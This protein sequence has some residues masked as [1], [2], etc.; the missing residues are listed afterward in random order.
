MNINVKHGGCLQTYFWIEDEEHRQNK[1][2][3]T[4][5]IYYY[6]TSNKVDFGGVF[7]FFEYFKFFKLIKNKVATY[8]AFAYQRWSIPAM[9]PLKKRHDILKKKCWT[10]HHHL[11]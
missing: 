7:E 9:V 2:S 6:V 5:L 10:T 11:Y 8:V 4:W 3:K 1:E